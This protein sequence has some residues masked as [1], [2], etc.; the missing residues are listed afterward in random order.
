MP[1][2]QH[3][4]SGQLQYIDADAHLENSE[5]LS[6]LLDDIRMGIA[7]AQST[8]NAHEPSPAHLARTLV[9]VDSLSFLQWLSLIHI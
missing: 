2:S 6:S 1:L 9:V 7:V 4:A 3:T 5:A 8:T